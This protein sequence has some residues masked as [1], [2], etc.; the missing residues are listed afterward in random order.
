M[1][2]YTNM[3]GVSGAEQK[4]EG[5]MSQTSPTEE[6]SSLLTKPGSPPKSDLALLPGPLGGRPSRG[7]VSPNP[8]RHQ[9]TSFGCT[10]SS[11][12]NCIPSHLRTTMEW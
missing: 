3:L 8:D 2:I 4:H 6:N 9:H 5:T 1:K 11:G 7:S 12:S 10:G